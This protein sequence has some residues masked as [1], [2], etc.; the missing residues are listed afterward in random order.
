MPIQRQYS[1]PD[2][3]LTLDGLSNSPETA[4]TG[5]R[6]ELSVLTRFECYFAGEK[7]PLVGG[8]ELLD[9]L[10]K[11]TNDCAQAWISGIKSAT[12][13]DESKVQIQPAQDGGF[14]LTVPAAL[15]FQGTAASLS[16][17]DALEKPAQVLHIS[18]VQLF[19]L[20]E[21]VDQ[22]TADQQTL[23]ELQ[24]SIQPRSRKEVM[25]PQL[26]LEQSAPIALGA[27]SVA[28]AAAAVF[29]IPAPKV[30]TP[31]KALQTQPTIGKP[32]F[33][34]GVPPKAKTKPGTSKTSIQKPVVSPRP[35]PPP[36]QGSGASSQYPS[37]PS[38]PPLQEDSGA[39]SQYPSSP[40]Q[41]DSGTSP[42]NSS[43]P[44]AP[45][46]KGASSPSSP[47]TAL[48][49]KGALPAYPSPSIA[50]QQE[51]ASPQYLSPSIAPQQE[52]ALPKPSQPI[53]LEPK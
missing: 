29:F 28:I 30:P 9:S 36:Q 41:Q 38:A 8:R 22:L 33:P 26:V 44:S 10:V 50:P 48:S 34:A 16:E 23:P 32:E 49:Q 13:T 20:M 45:P 1:L 14:T 3:V 2:C 12:K 7:G 42:Q 40:P 35:A 47:S 25:S 19:D 53:P 39:S 11:A 31:P 43:P 51:G 52:G 4:A 37:S 27:A 24:A 15:L 6:T 5:N 21:A 46:K 17:T 18:A